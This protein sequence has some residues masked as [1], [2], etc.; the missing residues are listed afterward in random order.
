MV[1]RVENLALVKFSLE[2]GWYREHFTMNEIERTSKDFFNSRRHLFPLLN[3]T[4]YYVHSL[5]LGFPSYPM[6]DFTKMS[7]SRDMKRMV[8]LIYSITH[9]STSK[10]YGCDFYPPPVLKRLI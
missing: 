9:S 5:L 2:A 7:I 10:T 3:P 6:R 8:K 4:K 1:Y